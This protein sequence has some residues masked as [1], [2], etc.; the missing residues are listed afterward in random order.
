MKKQLTAAFWVFAVF[1]ALFVAWVVAAEWAHPGYRVDSQGNRELDDEGH[2]I[3]RGA[4]LLPGPGSVVVEWYELF[5]KHDFIADVA[6][7]VKR[8]SLG[9]L[10]AIVP[11]FFLGVWFGVSPRVR[12]AVTPFF[13]FVQYIPPVAFVPILILWLGIGLSQQVSLLFI[14]TFFYL[15][16][17]VAETVANTPPTY[18][19][20]A[21]TLGARRYQLVW[22][23]IVPHGMPEFI[24]HLRVMVGIG[25]TYLT[26]VEMVSAENGIG[27][28]IITS[29]RYLQ[30]GRVLAGL[31]TIGVLGILFDLFLRGTAR[32]FCGWKY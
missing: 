2:A 23:V 8:I 24:Q 32:L 22:N 1:A 13:A 20:A 25:W 19:D 4:V 21:L 3:A 16:V 17:M 31:V 15:T 29:Q 6:Q 14:G 30:T 28:V 5:A 10:S 11:A 12:A 18:H 7:S 27:K 26:A 9:L